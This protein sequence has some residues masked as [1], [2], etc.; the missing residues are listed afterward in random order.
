MGEASRTFVCIK[1]R[2]AS[3]GEHY[4]NQACTGKALA[5]LPNFRFA[6]VV[7]GVYEKLA[8][9]ALGLMM[10]LSSPSPEIKRATP[11]KTHAFSWLK[12]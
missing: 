12:Q 11:S 1:L 4:A 3:K 6:V 8:T 2:I 10:K 9:V 5:T 7:N